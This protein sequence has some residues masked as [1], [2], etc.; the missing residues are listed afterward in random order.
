M[1]RSRRTSTLALLA[2]IALSLV[3]PSGWFEPDPAAAARAARGSDAPTGTPPAT[4]GTYRSASSATNTPIT[5]LTIAKPTGTTT[6][7]VL[8][9][10]LTLRG[11]AITITPPAGWTQVRTDAN[12]STVNQTIYRKVA[13]G[14]EPASYAFTFSVPVS[15]AVGG[16]V[17]YSGV[18]TTNPVDVHG[19]QTNASSTSVTAPS[20]TTTVADAMLVGFFGTGND[21]S[22]TT[23]SGMTER[24]DTDADGSSQVAGAADDVAQAAAGASGTKV[25]TAGIAAAN[26]GQL[27]ALKPSASLTRGPPSPR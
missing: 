4:P 6:N 9:A 19:G 15:A 23:P 8:L 22:F 18:D 25:A 27:V 24:F 21:T 1:G 26:V 3:S 17:A 20:V 13:G 11:A 10:S 12:G 14:S 7:D 5:G 2:L 16:M